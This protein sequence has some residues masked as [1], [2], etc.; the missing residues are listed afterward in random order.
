MTVF[1]LATFVVGYH[2][3]GGAMYVLYRFAAAIR[4]ES[5]AEDRDLAGVYRPSLTARPEEPTVP[6]VPVP[7]AEPTPE[8]ARTVL[9]P[10]GEDPLTY[11]LTRSDVAA[12][13]TPLADE[14]EV[15]AYDPEGF[16]DAWISAGT[17]ARA[18]AMGAEQ[19]L[20]EL[21]AKVEAARDVDADTTTEAV[22]L[23]KAA[24]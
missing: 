11:A 17:V 6:I 23:R 14:Q 18:L 20:V 12:E 22:D 10:P 1:D 13:P 4:R 8:P 9:I 7:A 16:T 2:L 24:A 21:I 5:E 19:Q 15:P 3:L